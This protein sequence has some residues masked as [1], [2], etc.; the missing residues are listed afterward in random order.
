MSQIVEEVDKE[1]LVTAATETHDWRKFS[2]F[3][4]IKSRTSYGSL[5]YIAELLKNT[6]SIQ[7]VELQS[8]YMLPWIHAITNIVDAIV[9][10]PGIE[11]VSFSRIHCPDLNLEETYL[12]FLTEMPQL[13]SLTLSM[14]NLPSDQIELLFRHLKDAKHL[15][16]FTLADCK[17][18]ATHAKSIAEAMSENSS[19]LHLDISNNFEDEAGVI[20]DI[21]CSGLKSN[22]SLTSL[23]FQGIGIAPNGFDS[24]GELLI[25]HRGIE[26]I[27]LSS[28]L[29]KETYKPLTFLKSIGSSSS[30]LHT[31]NMSNNPLHSSII[32]LA[33]AIRNNS[34]L[35]RLEFNWV[36]SLDHELAYFIETLESKKSN[37]S[38]LDIGRNNF[39]VQS[40][41]ALTRFVQDNSTLT[42]LALSSCQFT[43]SAEV[44]IPLFESL[45]TN[46]ALRVVLLD[47]N[48]LAG[49]PSEALGSAMAV[50]ETI[51]K[52]SLQA[53]NVLSTLY[54]AQVFL[55]F[56][57]SNQSLLELNLES[58]K[59]DRLSMKLLK[60]MVVQSTTLEQVS[61]ASSSFLPFVQTEEE[62]KMADYM[63][64]IR[65]K[66]KENRLKHNGEA[67]LLFLQYFLSK[68]MHS[69]LVDLNLLPIMFP[70]IFQTTLIVEA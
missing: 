45:R 65:N 56:L 58:N 17:V 13:K 14:M 31:L 29:W 35:T 3:T 26:S 46:Q 12:R 69:A 33:D 6:P 41:E 4:G 10:C 64:A 38:F 61:I 24:I 11:N 21:I 36:L 5:K 32:Y 59:I 68:K 22:R 2:K 8:Y 54:N 52:L 20:I 1:E 70:M 42:H 39:G 62:D 55:Q 57:D 51:S 28:N 19:I 25:R 18:T 7:S 30:S 47:D 48:N 23:N 60:D 34:S 63:V 67:R 27:N 43:K 50:N 49:P 9:K 15:R 53:S 37:I 40:A 44:M 16:S 66:M